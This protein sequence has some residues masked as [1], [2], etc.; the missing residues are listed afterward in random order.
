V[1]AWIERR[2][3]LSADRAHPFALEESSELSVDRGDTLEPGVLGDGLRAGV[4][5]PVEVVRDRQDLA[6]EV[7]ASQT[8]VALALLGGPSLEVQEFG[9]LALERGQVLVGLRL[10]LGEL[11]IEL[12]DVGQ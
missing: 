5:G 7:L 10:G 11:A 4:D 2:A 6:D 1:L 9:A 8:E 12:L 3:R